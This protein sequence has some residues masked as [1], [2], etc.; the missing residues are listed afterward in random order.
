MT[1]AKA[2]DLQVVEPRQVAHAPEPA[3]TDALMRL[4]ER[5]ATSNELDVAKLEKLLDM[6]ERWEAAEARKAYIEAKAAFKANAPVLEKNKHVHYRGK[7]GKPDTDY[8]H[9]TLDYIERQISPVLSQ[10]GLTYSWL[11]DQPGNAMISVTCELTHV[12]GHSERVTLSASPDQSGGKNNIQAVGSTVTYLQRYTLLAVTGLSTKGQDTDGRPAVEFI[13]D[14]QKREIIDLIRET[15]A[16]TKKF[17]AY[18][19]VPSVDELPAHKFRAAI[20]AL[21]KKAQ[22]A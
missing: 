14:D 2:H 4:I 8:D 6:K 7:D 11:T 13:T 3:G 19:E 16:D 1:E 5:A 20:A 10:Y 12:M 21:R 15:S 18:F 17:L 22:K 9:A